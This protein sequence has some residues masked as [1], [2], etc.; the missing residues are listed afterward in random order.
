MSTHLF[1]ARKKA[2]QM[3]IKKPK[4]QAHW[5]DTTAGRVITE[6]TWPANPMLVALLYEH[7]SQ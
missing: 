4:S 7:S 6:S 5:C 3:Q 1:G 2:I